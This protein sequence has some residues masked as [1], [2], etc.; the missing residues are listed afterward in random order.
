MTPSEE[1]RGQAA[2][3]TIEGDDESGY[4]WS[5]YGPRGARQGQAESESEAEAAA[6]AAERELSLPETPDP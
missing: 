6:Q 3:W 1:E 2:G 5:A 4:R